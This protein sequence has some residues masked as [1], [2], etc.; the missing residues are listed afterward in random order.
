M[1]YD[2]IIMGAGMLLA[3]YF[4]AKL[5]KQEPLIT[6]NKL[7]GVIDFEEEESMGKLLGTGE[8]VGTY[9]GENETN[10]E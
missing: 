7:P 5:T 1:W 2:L 6:S 3:F 4:G 8:K 9:N 10:S